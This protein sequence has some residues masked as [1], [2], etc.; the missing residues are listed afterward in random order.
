[1]FK[2]LKDALKLINNEHGWVQFIPAAIA[3]GSALAGALKKKKSAS[4]SPDMSELIN[5]IKAGAER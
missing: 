4:A 5:Q 2:L 3:A 1:M